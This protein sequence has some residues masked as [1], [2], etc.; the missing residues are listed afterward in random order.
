MNQGTQGYSLTKKTEGRKSRDTV[1]LIVYNTITKQR[2]VLR[3]T[4]SCAM[5]SLRAS[6]VKILRE[7]I[8]IIPFIK[9]GAASWIAPVAQIS[10]RFCPAL[11]NLKISRV[12][13][14]Q[15]CLQ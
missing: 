14:E 1:S 10:G 12:F 5:F 3:I 15:V 7:K 9:K 11:L 8:I 6:N 4:L 13:S 2:A